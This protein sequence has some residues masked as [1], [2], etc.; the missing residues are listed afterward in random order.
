MLLTNE[1]LGING[2]GGA[3]PKYGNTGNTPELTVFYVKLSRDS[4]N[5]IS[6]LAGAPTIEVFKVV[7]CPI[8]A[9]APSLSSF[10]FRLN[11]HFSEQ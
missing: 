6:F 2:Y 3:I 9:K 1:A 8:N 11:L 10:A 5:P 7:S 4:E